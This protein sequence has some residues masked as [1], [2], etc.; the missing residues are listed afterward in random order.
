MTTI[1]HITESTVEDAALD[2]LKGLGWDTA[3]GPDIAP[4]TPG[5]ERADYGDVVLARR[6]QDALVRLNSDLPAGALDDAFRKLTRLGGRM[7]CRR[8]RLPICW[9]RPFTATRIARL[10][11]RILLMS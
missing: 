5:A 2:Y 1:T 6:L 4:D 8:G 10:R 3:H 9:S 11:R 7:W